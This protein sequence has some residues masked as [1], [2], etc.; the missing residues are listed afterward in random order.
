[1][2]TEPTPL[3]PGSDRR[4]LGLLLGS[5]LP[6][7]LLVAVVAAATIGGSIDATSPTPAAGE[8]G[9]SPAAAA[10]DTGSIGSAPALGIPVVAK[11]LPVLEVEAALRRQG[12]GAQD[13]MAISGRLSMSGGSAGCDITDGDLQASGFGAELGVV[14]TASTFCDR[15]GILR[16]TETTLRPAA[17]QHIHVQLTIG[18]VLPDLAA[19]PARSPVPAILI[20]RFLPRQPTCKEVRACEPRF[21]VDAV[22]WVDGL[23]RGPMV[24]VEPPLLLSGLRLAWRVR[25]RLASDVVGPG[26]TT[27]FETLVSP[28][29]LTRLDQAAATAASVTAA[30]DQRIWYRRVLDRSP[31]TDPVIR[32]V[33]IDDV[34]GMVL[35]A[36]IVS[37]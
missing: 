1:M 32:W 20:G 23:W 5:A 27:L 34:V 36:G 24:T 22:V 2:L 30:L 19:D 17:A 7:V 37:D 14:S 21:Q 13:V 18:T 8:A 9:A 33:A 25:D 26:R 10:S 4:R 15:V 16:P 28:S 31:E 29:T 12:S 35:G 6:L 3:Q 11:G